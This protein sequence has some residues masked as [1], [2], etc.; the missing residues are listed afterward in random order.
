[1]GDERASQLN[2]FPRLK[3]GL[4]NWMLKSF[5]YWPV[6]AFWEHLMLRSQTVNVPN[7]SS[8]HTINA[9]AI[10]LGTIN[11]FVVIRGKT[12]R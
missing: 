9:G 5:G 3:T 11:A 7:E 2:W 12:I 8:W 4:T 10:R 6:S 1:M